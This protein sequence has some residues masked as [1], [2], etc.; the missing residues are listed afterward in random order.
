MHITNLILQAFAVWRWWNFCSGQSAIGKEVLKINLDETSICLY[1]GDVKGNAFM[2]KRCGREPVQKVGRGKRRCCLTH[3]AFVCNRPDVQRLLPHILIGNCRTFRAKDMASLRRVCPPNVKLIRQKSAW[4]NHLLCAQIMQWFGAAL[5]PFMERMQPILL[6]D[7]VRVHIKSNVISACVRACIF[8]I[9]VP[10]RMTW[11]LQPLDTHVFLGFKRHLRK[12]Y[13]AA[14]VHSYDG[15]I[16]T[17]SFL[18]CVYE[19]IAYVFEAHQWAFAFTKDGY[20]PRQAGISSYIR[21]QLGIEAPLQITAA[22]PTEEQ[23]KLC[24]PRGAR[25][26]IDALFPLY[27]PAPAPI[28]LRTDRVAAALA[29]SAPPAIFENRTR[30]QHRR[31][32]QAARLIDPAVA[33]PAAPLAGPRRLARGYRMMFR[34]PL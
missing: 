22:S 25:L 13:Q 17:G 28:A 9:V 10:A 18:A 14:R 11:L 20:G 2:K 12:T 8:P 5:A 6:L 29:L 16:D 34:R 7:A 1:Q 32:Q 3:V 33:E 31:A 4:N 27:G 21:E 30:G 24:F 23:L 19:T 15:D 26:P